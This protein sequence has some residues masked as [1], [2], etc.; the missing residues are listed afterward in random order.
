MRRQKSKADLDKMPEDKF[1]SLRM[2]DL[3]L[4]IQGTWI[5]ECVQELYAELKNKGLKF[6]PAVYLAEEWLTPEDEPIIGIPFYLAHPALMKLEQKMM[7]EVE[8][9]T[10]K[11]CMQLLRHEAGHAITYAYRL[12]KKRRWQKVFGQS[13]KDYDDTYKYKPYSRNFVRHLDGFYAQY[14][15]DE[16]FSETF[17]VWLT[18]ELDWQAH[19]MN[20]K[21]IKKLKYVDGL[22]IS[23]QG[24]DPLIRKGKPYWHVRSLKRTLQSHYRK[25]QMLSAEDL[26]HFHDINLKRIF[27]E[28]NEE[29]KK[30]PLAVSC[31]RK[32][33]K[34]I[35]NNVSMWTGERKYIINNLFKDV[36]LR[37][38]GL[39]LVIKDSESTAILKV[40]TYLTALVM[41]YLYTGWFRGNN[42]KR[43]P[44]SKHEH[45]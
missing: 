1:L 29:N 36:C 16:D 44:Y 21:A 43:Y 6:R 30:S 28:R 27:V 3:P 45:L 2:C 7:L 8:G 38:R 41:N 10:K 17:S 11:T 25:R 14:H 37:C 15:P 35:L 40:A 22:M 23:L 19:Y 32:Y 31:I 34:E 39:K 20:W 5:E 42:R 9:G 13:S 26:P 24:K 18:P 12:N 4:K 33:R